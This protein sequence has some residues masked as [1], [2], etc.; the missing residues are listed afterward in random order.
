MFFH[1]FTLFV[2]HSVRKDFETFYVFTPFFHTFLMLFK[3]FVLKCVRKDFETCEFGSRL[4]L[5]FSQFCFVFTLFVEIVNSTP[6]KMTESVSALVHLGHV[7]S[8]EN[9]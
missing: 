6:S 8:I 2:L 7:E 9:R 1:V 3:L 4:F 5:Y